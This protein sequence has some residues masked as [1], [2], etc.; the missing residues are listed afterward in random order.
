MT[1]MVT[2]FGLGGTFI[3]EAIYKHIFNAGFVSWIIP[4]ALI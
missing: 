1:P 4:L 2:S 3:K